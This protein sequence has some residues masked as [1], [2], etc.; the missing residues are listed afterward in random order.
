[1]TGLELAALASIGLGLLAA[2]AALRIRT[3]S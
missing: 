2:G 1:M 3:A